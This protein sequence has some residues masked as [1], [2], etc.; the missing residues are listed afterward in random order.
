M[1][2][3]SL[4]THMR[5]FTKH[6]SQ[7]YAV[8]HRPHD[9]PHFHDA[10]ASAHVLV[11]LKNPNARVE[12]KQSAVHKEIVQDTV[13][14]S[15]KDSASPEDTGVSSSDYDYSQHLRPMGQNPDAVYIPSRTTTTAPR[16]RDIAD[17]FVEP[18]YRDA[19]HSTTVRQPSVQHDPAYLAQQQT[20][21]DD[22]TGFRP[23][24][25]P[26]LREV[27]EALEDEAYVVNDDVAEGNGGDDDDL[28]AELLAG[29]EGE[30][31]GEEFDEWDALDAIDDFEEQQYADEMR[32]FDNVAS[33]QDLQGIDYQADVRR[34]V[35]A[36]IS[37][38]EFESEE[39][40]E[41]EQ[42]DMLGDLPSF[43]KGAKGRRRKGAMSDVSGF[44]MTSSAVARTETMTVLDDQY[45]SIIAGYENYEDEQAEDEEREYK[46]FDM[47]AER[48]D[49]EGLVDDFLDNY[50]L[51]SGGRKI[52]RKDKEVQ[53]YK[54][55]ADAVSKGKLSMRRNREKKKRDE[56]GKVASSLSSLRF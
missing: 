3:A 31:E 10:D 17:M 52:V 18:A 22:I 5:R 47:G 9:D 35:R 42:E 36:G 12:V 41:E 29:G 33:L 48:A 55:A 21:P 4:L 15:A 44:S 20:A 25:D 38:D 19:Q 13:K 39:E 11:P 34:A 14:D 40:E 53:K 30:G 2:V 54:D 46:P 26:R 56:V 45:D 24:M 1:F 6:N 49:F 51:E 23:D 28:L 8:V 37:D 16:R 50:E 7:R 43:G 32:Q 27:L